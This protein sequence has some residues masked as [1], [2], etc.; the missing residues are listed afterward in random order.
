MA[1]VIC[2]SV[3]QKSPI[4]PLSTRGA[5]SLRLA[6]QSRTQRSFGGLTCESAETMRSAMETPPEADLAEDAAV[7]Q[8]IVR[9]RQ[10]VARESARLKTSN[11]PRSPC[12]V[13][14]PIFFPCCFPTN[15]T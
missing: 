11:A 2:E 14:A 10:M 9:L 13:G 12:A 1:P 5:R 3:I 4:G 6:G 15:L 8:A 7:N